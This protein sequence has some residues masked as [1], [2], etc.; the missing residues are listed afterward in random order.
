MYARQ[1]RMVY[2]LRLAELLVARL[3]RFAAALLPVRRD[4]SELPPSLIDGE[5]LSQESIRM[6]TLRQ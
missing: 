4:S 2:R 6:S 1:D 5:K 3:L